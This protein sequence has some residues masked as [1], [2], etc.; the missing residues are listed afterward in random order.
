MLVLMLALW[1]LGA[2][3]VPMDFRANAAERSLLAKEFDLAAIV[4][5]RQ[6]AASGYESFP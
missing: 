3:A 1:M 4:E 5:D 2:T 6:L